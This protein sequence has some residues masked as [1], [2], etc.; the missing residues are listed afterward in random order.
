[1]TVH[2]QNWWPLFTELFQRSNMPQFCTQGRWKRS[3]FVVGCKTLRNR[4]S[5]STFAWQKQVTEP[6]Q[7]KWLVIVSLKVF[8]ERF[9]LGICKLTRRYRLGRRSVRKK[10]KAWFFL[11]SMYSRAIVNFPACIWKVSNATRGRH[12]TEK[13]SKGFR[14]SL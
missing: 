10:S 2:T 11:G 12:L 5:A 9:Y 7:F 3:T 6:Y 8:W 1:M 14:M 4:P 13:V